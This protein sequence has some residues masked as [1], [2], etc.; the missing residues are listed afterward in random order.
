[1]DEALGGYSIYD[2]GTR[3]VRA[4][5]KLKFAIETNVRLEGKIDLLYK[6]LIATLISAVG[7]LGA[8]VFSLLK[9]G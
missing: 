3:L 8:T 2:I 9:H 1:M 7:S 5:E 4:E 6:L